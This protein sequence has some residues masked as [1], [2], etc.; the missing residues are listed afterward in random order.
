MFQRGELQQ[1]GKRFVVGGLLVTA[2]TLL[3]IV[4]DEVSS[5]GNAAIRATCVLFLWV[6]GVTITL[7]MILRIVGSGHAGARP[8]PVPPR[9][10]RRSTNSR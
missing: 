5:G 3:V 8:K 10:A 2:I 6:G 4:A 7:G 1:I 9:R